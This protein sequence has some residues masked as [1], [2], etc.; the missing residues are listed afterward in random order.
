MNQKGGNEPAL[1]DF[2]QETISNLNRI[3]DT[4]GHI[5]LAV[6]SSYQLQPSASLQLPTVFRII[7]PSIVELFKDSAALLIK[8]V[9][10]EVLCT[11]DET[12]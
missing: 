12:H 7:P 2:P 9:K 1:R 3:A 4:D 6:M 11:E 5:P 8:Q 10:Y